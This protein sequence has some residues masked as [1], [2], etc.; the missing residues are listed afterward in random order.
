MSLRR[1]R[2]YDPLCL[3]SRSDEAIQLRNI[4]SMLRIIQRFG[5]HSTIATNARENI[6]SA[7]RRLKMLKRF[8]GGL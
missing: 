8:K 5:Q 7:K 3:G 6:R 2:N 1:P 4:L